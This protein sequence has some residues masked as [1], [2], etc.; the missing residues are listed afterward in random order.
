M[1]CGGGAGQLPLE[2]V[3]AYASTK[4]PVTRHDIF[5]LER[6]RLCESNSAGWIVLSLWTGVD[7]TLPFCLE[8]A[9]WTS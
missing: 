8:L 2:V 3:I 5:A 6:R 4:I 1:D 9:L 7:A